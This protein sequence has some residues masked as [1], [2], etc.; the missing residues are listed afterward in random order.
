[1][2]SEKE[3]KIKTFYLKAVG[4][5][6]LLGIITVFIV[7]HFGGFSYK[8]IEEP[9]SIEKRGKYEVHTYSGNSIILLYFNTPFKSK[10]S[11]VKKRR[12]FEEVNQSSLKNYST[13]IVYYF[14]GVLKDFLYVILFTGLYFLIILFF[15]RHKFKIISS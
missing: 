2:N 4:L 7:E 1:M 15:N 11:S 12:D 14:K 6:F 5:A 8:N 13:R 3:I 10:V 9:T